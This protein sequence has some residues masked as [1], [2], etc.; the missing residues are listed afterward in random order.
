MGLRAGADQPPV[1]RG[2]RSATGIEQDKPGF[3]DIGIYV[4]SLTIAM[5]AMITLVATLVH[6]FSIG[7]MREDKRFPRFFTY[8]G[9]VLLLDARPG[10]RR[11]DAA[12]VHLLGAGRPV[13]A[14]C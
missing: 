8:L 5:F 6:V 1:S 10:D 7:Y 4:D 2:S 14:T 3:L 12:A 13:L 11:D 9:P